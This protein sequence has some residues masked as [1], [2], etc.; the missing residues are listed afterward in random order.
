MY[1]IPFKKKTGQYLIYNVI[2]LM[3]KHIFSTRIF[4]KLC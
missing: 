2:I 4:A 3:E 1:Q